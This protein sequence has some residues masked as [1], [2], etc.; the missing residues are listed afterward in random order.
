MI[1]LAF[2][3]P[4]LAYWLVEGRF[5]KQVSKKDLNANA[6]ALEQMKEKRQEEDPTKYVGLGKVEIRGHPLLDQEI[7]F[8]LSDPRAFAL[9]DE[10]LKDI[11]VF[12]TSDSCFVR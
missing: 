8:T 5:Y 1:F 7:D 12:K 6:N 2:G 9:S 3:V 10:Q 4:Y 11:M